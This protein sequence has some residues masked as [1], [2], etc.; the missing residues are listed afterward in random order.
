MLVVPGLP[1]PGRT[2]V[3]GVINVTPDSFSDGGS[4]FDHAAA[5]RHGRELI[6]EGADIIDIGGESTRPGAVRVDPEEELRRTIPVIRELAGEESVRDGR[7]AISVD[8]MRA[9]T[10]EEAYKAGARLINDVSG[11]QADPAMIPVAA[12][13]GSA[14]VQMHWRGHSADMQSRAH[15]ADVVA[16]VRDELARL[17][18]TAIAA[19]IAEDRLILD[20]G[21]GF[22]KTGDHNW[23]LMQHLDV[24]HGLGRPLL[25]AAS[26]KRFLGTLLA[27]PDGTPRP[28]K[29]RDDATAALSTWAA[30]QRM[31]AVRVHTVRASRDAIAVVERLSRH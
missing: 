19:G 25:F 3:I 30:L 12:A 28:P 14:Y 17:A 10:A 21:F 18:D 4:Y 7:V 24:L 2:L 31:W 5:V 6:A 20:P 26:R 8:T 22:A 27:D 23:E 29:G 1:A 11:G 13:L 16:E 9:R 15:Y